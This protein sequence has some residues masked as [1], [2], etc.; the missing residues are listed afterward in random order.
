MGMKVL[1]VDLHIKEV[2]IN[3]DIH[4]ASAVT[5]KLPSVPMDE[6]LAAADYI[7]L[8]VPSTGKAIIG[9]A[10]FEKMKDGV[11][12]ANPARGGTIDEDALLAAL[13]SGKVAGAG[14]DVFVNE[15]TPRTDLLNHPNVS[16]S[17]HI[18]GS[19][20]EAQRNIGMELAEKL[21]GF[22]N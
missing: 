17:P 9:A 16:L 1:P 8:H 2:S 7:T 3:L 6:M 12:I 13:N 19:T 14:L 21:N 18:G 10:E 5:V 22:F 11:V 4:G 15:P 20:V